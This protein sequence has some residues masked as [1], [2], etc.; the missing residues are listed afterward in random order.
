MIIGQ[1]LGKQEIKTLFDNIKHTSFTLKQ[2]DSEVKTLFR[3][4]LRLVLEDIANKRTPPNSIKSIGGNLHHIDSPDIAKKVFETYVSEVDFIIQSFDARNASAIKA[5]DLNYDFK[6]IVDFQTS[7]EVNH[8]VFQFPIR[9]GVCSTADFSSC[10]FQP[11]IRG[12]LD[13]T[14]EGSFENLSI[15][16]CFGSQLKIKAGAEN[17]RMRDSCHWSYIKLDLEKCTSSFIEINHAKYM[18]INTD[19]EM[20]SIYSYGVDVKAEIGSLS[21]NSLTRNDLGHKGIRKFELGYARIIR[22]AE[23]QGN[24]ELSFLIDGVE[25]N[26]PPI[27][28]QPLAL[29]D[30]FHM[31]NYSIKETD[32]SSAGHMK[33]LREIS[34][35]TMPTR[36]ILYLH[37]L[38]QRCL[39]KV[40]SKTNPEYWLSFLIDRVTGFGTYLLQP[41]LLLCL[42]GA[43]M[44][45]ALSNFDS[46]WHQRGLFEEP[47][48]ND[49]TYTSIYTFKTMLGPLRLTLFTDLEPIN[50]WL[51]MLSVI[52]SLI[53]SFLIYV[54]LNN[55]RKRFKVDQ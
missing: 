44:F 34:E 11:N 41:F 2:L 37:S 27:F 47:Q 7:L 8:K 26:Y 6:N 18:E 22:T 9:F 13:Y 32:S 19:S 24:Y 49:K 30:H 38:E 48:L 43:I 25:F 17:F 50:P 28:Y 55:I 42:L 31:S 20:L 12:T 52:L 54:F 39:R 36:D 5:L 1:Y 46:G 10:E 23:F 14:I 15:H 21:V 33:V 4:L 3:V 51:S 53:A 40:M 45:S 16:D 35:R 29:P